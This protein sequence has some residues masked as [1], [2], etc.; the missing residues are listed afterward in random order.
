MVDFSTVPLPDPRIS[1]KLLAKFSKTHFSG[2]RVNQAGRPVG[3]C[4][5]DVMPVTALEVGRGNWTQIAY[6]H[7]DGCVIRLLLRFR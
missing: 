1:P 6:D 2:K 5:G 4:N 3:E 7:G